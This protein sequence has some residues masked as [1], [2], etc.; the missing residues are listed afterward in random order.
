MCLLC[1]EVYWCE[2]EG[3]SVSVSGSVS[4]HMQPVLIL[5]NLACAST[6]QVHFEGGL[7]DSGVAFVRVYIRI[8][9]L[10]FVQTPWRLIITVRRLLFLS[11]P[12]LPPSLRPSVPPTLW[13][14]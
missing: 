4:V 14:C 10:N 12:S 1:V 8:K 2:G 3:V 9:M 11:S 13:R 6:H 7:D 5:L